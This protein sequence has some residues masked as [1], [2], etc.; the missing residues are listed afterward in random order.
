[1]NKSPISSQHSSRTE[2]AS[3]WRAGM[4]ASEAVVQIFSFGG[5][6]SFVGEKKGV[7]FSPVEHAF[8]DA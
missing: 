7:V 6:I 3:Y 1:M 4:E 2:G 8:D 5:R